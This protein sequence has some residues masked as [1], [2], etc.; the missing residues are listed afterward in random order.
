[1][2]IA[3]QL[4]V[5]FS[6]ALVVAAPASAA[7][8]WRPPAKV[9]VA[10]S[11][12]AL[13][14]P[15]VATRPG[16][17]TSVAFERGSSVYASTR[18]PAGSFAPIQSLGAIAP[19]K[20][21]SL[22]SGGGIAALAWDGGSSVRVAL[23]GGCDSFSPAASIPGS[24]ASAEEPVAAVDGSGRA[25]LA[26]E[27]G[28]SGSRRIYVSEVPS[29][30]SP[31][32]AEP[33]AP[34][35]GTEAFRAKLAVNGAAAGL[36]FDVVSGGN[37]V[38][39]TL[40]VGPQSWLAPV[41][42]N[43]ADKP[44]VAG[45]T[46]V[47][48]GA[49]GSLHAVWIDAGNKEVILGTL[50]PSGTVSRATLIIAGGTVRE[51][52]IATDAA[53]RLAVVW[54][55]QTGTGQARIYGKHREPGGSLSPQRSVSAATSEFRG[56]PR[57]AIDS[58]GRTIVTWSEL[59]EVA[60]TQATAA[61]T[62]L[63][64]SGFYGGSGTISDDALSTTPS[65]ISTDGA[66]NTVA[67]LY[68]QSP[69][70]RE[71]QVAAFDAAGPLLSGLSVPSGLVGAALPFSISALDAWSPTAPAGWDFGDGTGAVGDAATHAYA[72]AGSFAVKATVA[73]SLG[74]TSEASGVATTVP[75][76]PPGGTPGG[77]P[78]GKPVGVER[79][80]GLSKLKLRPARF[81][82]GP[83]RGTGARVSFRLSER[84][85]LRFAVKPRGGSFARF[86]RAGTN[87]FRFSGRIRGKALAP[88]VYRLRAVAIDASGKRS[89]PRF[90]RFTVVLP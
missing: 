43:A 78:G 61:A 54:A 66:G 19:D 32:S 81:V 73:D 39:G 47:A 45:K 89:K 67:A 12:S 52:A 6:V 23:A 51:P 62:R 5:T 55:E 29:A 30:G 15:K 4:L 27:A 48:V 69:T 37:Q 56:N 20:Y 50:T 49:D 80:P 21:P 40:R 87:R 70:P 36:A 84:A 9:E 2:R 11:A 75:G 53:G 68:V 57:V 63:P 25:L 14:F 85:R 83:G 77:G 34:P 10:P 18:P 28:G 90:A 74:N 46:E 79:A 71:A 42:L 26:F 64:G 33:L 58:L 8:A 35:A 41:Q 22:A 59:A 3:L 7:P 17:C 76:P 88:G 24:N 86:G 1:M 60:A 38:Y 82:V 65:G 44:A 31:M 13:S 16:G 72:A